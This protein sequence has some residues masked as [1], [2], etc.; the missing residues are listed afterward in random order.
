[1]LL[2]PILAVLLLIALHLPIFLCL[3]ARFRWRV[4]FHSL[5]LG[6]VVLGCAQVVVAVYALG[7]A[8]VLTPLSLLLL[9][10][11]GSGA[12]V[13][14]AGRA[15]FAWGELR[16]VTAD[17]LRLLRQALT[18]PALAA[19][20]AISV[21][22]VALLVAKAW[23][24]PP[25][26]YDGTYS[27][28]SVARELWQD[29]GLPT[30]IMP[31][32][33]DG[34]SPFVPH[35]FYAIE[36]ALPYGYDWVN[37]TNIY[38]LLLAF[39]AQYAFARRLG[40]RRSHALLVSPSVLVFPVFFQQ[41]TTGYIDL[42]TAA[43]LGA[44][45]SFIPSR[46]ESLWYDVALAGA[47]LGLALGSKATTVLITV[48]LGL[49]ILFWASRLSGGRVAWRKVVL[50]M[51]VLSAGILLVGGYQYIG[52]TVR[53]RN[54]F[55]PVD[56]KAGPIHFRGPFSQE[57]VVYGS[58]GGHPVNSAYKEAS[59]LRQVW[60]SW[61]EENQYTNLRSYD[62]DNALG[63]FG[64]L[65]FVLF[66]PALLVGLVYWR[67]G[68]LLT[69]TLALAAS[70][71]LMSECRSVT[72]YTAFILFVGPPA[73]AYAASRLGKLGRGAWQ[74]ILVASMAITLFLN[75]A[76][77]Q[78]TGGQ[79]LRAFLQAP[80]SDRTAW[81][82][83]AAQFL[84]DVPADGQVVAAGLGPLAY[85]AVWNE[86]GS[87]TIRWL[88]DKSWM[89]GHGAIFCTAGPNEL[90][91]AYADPTVSFVVLPIAIHPG[92]PLPHLPDFAL[93]IPEEPRTG[94]ALMQ[95]PSQCSVWMRVR[96]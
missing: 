69:A 96:R 70:V 77:S 83:P 19:V 22:A 57:G 82:S 13:V 8:H 86:V 55:Y 11:A 76:F 10:A 35:V 80:R 3:W 37:G 48:F 72:R 63:G 46:R 87:D 16:S 58:I 51:T 32:P 49:V 78:D 88:L 15:G 84:R 5:L 42:P 24:Y 47:A 90:A 50:A 36:L 17:Y 60:M 30:Q 40:I 94:Y 67:H 75:V 43:F 41:A 61:R 64:P 4:P 71:A 89:D 62:A 21:A 73:Y 18:R 14:A 20:L 9:N 85:F 91:S 34:F 81:A 93:V 79:W 23:L 1:M 68:I 95:V 31:V 25:Y 12:W 59:P 28:L 2:T 54:P 66:L 6:A 29:R 92:Y 65:W 33:R 44:A 39:L 45:L 74:V 7:T 27:H 26:D 38:F 53:F 56:V 52:D